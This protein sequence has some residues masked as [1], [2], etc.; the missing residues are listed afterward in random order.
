MLKHV[1]NLIKLRSSQQF[2]DRH[3]EKLL[4]IIHFEDSMGSID[5]KTKKKKKR[6]NELPFVSVSPSSR[7]PT[8]KHML[9]LKKASSMNIPSH[10]R[11]ERVP[12]TP[13]SAASTESV[14][15]HI[16][17]SHARNEKESTQS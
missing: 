13:T 11:S 16:P 17:R 9:S 1:D 8:E 12:D 6:N 3:L 15:L 7:G 5:R 10:H 4:S 14:H 2:T